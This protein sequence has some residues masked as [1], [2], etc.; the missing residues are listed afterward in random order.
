[1][2]KPLLYYKPILAYITHAN[3][4]G[5][6]HWYEVVYYNEDGW[7]CYFGSNTFKDGEII[8]NWIYCHECL[9]ENPNHSR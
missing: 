2:S 3:S 1:M 9:P 6:S 7:Q 4:L 5:T 8:I